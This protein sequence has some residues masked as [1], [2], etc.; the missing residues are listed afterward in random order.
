MSGDD[1]LPSSNP[2]R[3][4][5]RWANNAASVPAST[6]IIRERIAAREKGLPDP[7]LDGPRSDDGRAIGGNLELAKRLDNELAAAKRDH[8]R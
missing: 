2:P 7:T 3:I 6:Q 1:Y 8:G 5:E 4:G